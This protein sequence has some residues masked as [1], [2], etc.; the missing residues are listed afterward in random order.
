MI[1][2]ILIT[3]SLLSWSPIGQSILE[4]YG[5]LRSNI[6]WHFSH[7]YCNPFTPFTPFRAIRS[8]Y[9][10]LSLMVGCL[11]LYGVI[12]KQLGPLQASFV[13]TVRYAWLIETCLCSLLFSNI[14]VSQV[15]IIVIAFFVDLLLMS[16][17]ETSSNAQLRSWTCDESSEN[18]TWEF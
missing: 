15:L 10:A 11:G 12:K 7:C 4:F 14:P 18:S 9:G 1:F 13:L 2:I 6:L 8:I 17:L 16:Q 5:L 3:N